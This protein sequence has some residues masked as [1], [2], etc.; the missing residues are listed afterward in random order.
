M[1]LTRFA[2]CSAALRDP[3]IGHGD[4]T[5]EQDV[6]GLTD[7]REHLSLRQFRTS[8]LSLDP[9]AHTRLRRLVSGA[10]TPRR[11]AGLQT[12]HR[13][14][15]TD[16]VARRDGSGLTDFIATFA[17]PLPIAVIGELLGVP[18]GGPAPVPAP[19]A[20]LDPGAGRDDSAH[21]GQGGCRGRGD[22]GLSRR[23]RAG[24]APSAAGRPDQRAAARRRARTDDRGR[25]ADDG[26]AAVRRR[27][28]DRDPSAR[29][30]TGR[31]AGPSRPAGTCWRSR[32]AWR[33]GRST[34]C[35]GSTA[36]CRSRG[37]KCC[38]TP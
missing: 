24:A 25:T 3:N 23:A 36:P 21:P 18:R 37:G 27:L 30:R 19:G 16:A 9:P 8:M 15:L 6:A 10:F 31:P 26:R 14:R 1:L 5:H 4:P 7:W 2:D 28:R 32:P 20:G 34:N 29:Q 17:F 13:P 33:P 12:V 35:S 22:P 11:V 38:G